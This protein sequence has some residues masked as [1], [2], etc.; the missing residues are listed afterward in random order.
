MSDSLIYDMSLGSEETEVPFL[1]KQMVYINDN[2]TSQKYGT[3]EII[4]DSLQLGSNG[5][6][7][8]MRNAYITIPLVLSVTGFVTGA[9]ANVDFTAAAVAGTDF[10]LCMKNSNLSLISSLMVEYNNTPLIMTQQNLNQYLIWKQH[11]STSDTNVNHALLGYAMDEPTSWQYNAAVSN[12]GSGISNNVCGEAFQPSAS[13]NNGKLFN[14]G[15]I[16]R[17]Q[18]FTN[19]DTTWGRSAI[20]SQASLLEKSQNI[21]I[22]STT[23]KTYHYT[24]VLRLRDIHDLFDKMP[25]IKGGNLKITLR[26]NDGYF[27]FSKGDAA[28]LGKLTHLPNSSILPGGTLPLMVSASSIYVSQNAGGNSMISTTALAVTSASYGYPSGC[29]N[30]PVECLFKCS[31]SVVQNIWGNGISNQMHK[32]TNC[33]LYCPSYTLQTDHEKQYIALGQRTIKYTDTFYKL[34]E[35][36]A[37]NSDLQIQITTSVVNP[38]RLIIIPMINKEVNGAQK[39]RPI[40]SPFATEPATC[41]PYSM[42]NINCYVSTNAIYQTN[43]PYTFETYC[44]EMNNFGLNGNLTNGI[45]SGKISYSHYI[46]TYGY[47]VID[48]TRKLPE[49]LNTSVSID[50]AFRITSLL[51]LDLYCFIEQEKSITVNLLNGSLVKV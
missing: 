38:R 44:N 35:N 3:H 24:A 50:F 18:T 25:L 43:Q 6:Y 39:I 34:F 14:S 37:V 8:D 45:S 32:M 36:Q 4:W 16:Q 29:A 21:I 11:V 26:V 20:F 49:D 46:N 23:E 47:I 41:S 22:D 15:M 48:L 17:S 5:K 10:M 1:T 2:N 28:S 13:Y 27:E 12:A 9:A 30:L 42:T 19:A 7:N 51:N 33:R 31:V 40:C